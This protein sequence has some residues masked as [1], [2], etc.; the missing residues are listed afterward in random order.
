MTHFAGEMNSTPRYVY[1]WPM[2][3]LVLF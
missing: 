3:I 2:I 1:N